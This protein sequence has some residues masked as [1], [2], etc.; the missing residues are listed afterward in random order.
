MFN[1]D[2]EFDILDPTPT[3]WNG[4]S[5]SRGSSD[6]PG[7]A[8]QRRLLDSP[9]V[10]GSPQTQQARPRSL[11]QFAPEELTSA[12]SPLFSLGT[13]EGSA[14]R[15]PLTTPSSGRRPGPGLRAVRSGRDDEDHPQ[16]TV[17]IIDGNGATIV[18]HVVPQVATYN[19]R[20]N[21]SR[22]KKVVFHYITV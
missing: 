4:L 8:S 15:E 22:K 19:A 7:G 12:S 13:P 20:N 3:T 17:T 11:P 9:L 14:D 2:E 6:T 10:R 18:A 21:K 5:V 16:E 1:G